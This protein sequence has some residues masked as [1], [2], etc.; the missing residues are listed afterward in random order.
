MFLIWFCA[1]LLGAGNVA[2]PADVSLLSS[3]V[4]KAMSIFRVFVSVS[5]HMC[6]FKS[7]FEYTQSPGRKPTFSHICSF[8]GK[9]LRL[10]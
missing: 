8:F 10:L 2:I 4:E 1:D 9:P 7:I 6:R 3:C 5:V